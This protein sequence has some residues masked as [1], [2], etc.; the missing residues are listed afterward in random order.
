MYNKIKGDQYENY[1]L[2]YITNET[3]EF[4]QAW[5]TKNIPNEIIINTNLNKND[6]IE[7]YKNCDIGFD[8]LAVKNNEYFFIQ[9]KNHNQ[10]LC[11]NDLCSFY[12]LLYEYNLNGIIYYTSNLSKRLYE[13]NNNKVEYRYLNMNNTKLD[14][15]LN[16]EICN[17]IEYR[18]YQYDAFNSLK[19]LN[20]A[21]LAIPCGMGKTYIGYLLSKEYKNIIIIA[22]T[23]VLTEELLNRFYQ[24]YK[25][26]YNPVLLSMD[27]QLDIEKIILL[28]NNIIATTYKSVDVLNNLLELNKDIK[29]QETL[30]IFDEYHN[31]S[32]NNLDTDKD[33]KKIKLKLNID[34][35]LTNK[36]NK[37]GSI[38]NNIDNNI[39]FLSATPIKHNYFK[40][41]PKYTYKWSDAI[42]NKYICDMKIIIPNKKE[43]PEKIINDFIELFNNPDNNKDIIIQT[44]FIIKN[45]INNKN[46]KLIIYI[47]NCIL[48]EKYKFII[49]YISNFFGIIVNIGE[50]TYNTS[51]INRKKI[52]NK[53]KAIDENYNILLNISILNEG[54]DIP[55]C[56]SIFITNYTDNIINTV[57][58]M[59]RCNRI[60]KTKTQCYIYLWTEQSNIETIYNYLELDNPEFIKSKILID[61]LLKEENDKIDKNYSFEKYLESINFTNMDFYNIYYEIYIKSDRN[62]DFIIDLEHVA[63]WL[64][65]RKSDL[66]KTLLKSYKINIEYNINIDTTKKNPG[67]QKEKILI[68]PNCFKNLCLLSKT[69]KAQEFRKYFIQLDNLMIKYR[70]E[71][72][73][74]LENKIK[75]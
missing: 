56:D 23:R 54:I 36:D 3:N 52:L 72:N 32:N 45:I 57:Q 4:E 73:K 60:T 51:K 43:L 24:Y 38:L 68:N 58:R 12:F 37:I 8:I 40:D 53:F 31:L 39:L 11:I 47:T 48:I 69:K 20:R 55:E 17:N 25:T 7:K 59:S 70:I 22:P 50:I 15:D 34:T 49:N 74:I 61:N 35:I 30:Y 62:N 2:N 75:E 44:Y 41:I 65:M 10:T 28:E 9:C 64:S 5:L 1:I 13:L 18:S 66:K 46:K 29:P 19:G 6:N 33:N 42:I 26:L 71:L 67:I 14:I 27:G 21:I 63:N 16:I